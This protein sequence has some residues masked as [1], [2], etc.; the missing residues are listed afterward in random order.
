MDHVF[1]FP[2]SINENVIDKHVGGQK[3]HFSEGWA[4]RKPTMAEMAEAINNGHAFGP[5]FQNGVRLGVNFIRAGFVVIDADGTMSLQDALADPFIQTYGAIIYTTPSHR[6][7]AE[8]HFR[9]VFV[10][11]T[12][13]ESGH[14]YK[15]AL[16][17]L[18]EKFNTDKV[19]D[20]ARVLFGSK[21]S[22]PTILGNILPDRELKA[23]IKLGRK[24]DR[25]RR[26][27]RPAS[28]NTPEDEAMPGGS[29]RA[30]YHV[31][32]DQLLRTAAGGTGLIIDMPWKTPIY[33]PFHA[34]ANPSAFILRSKQGDPG[35]HC[36]SCKKTWWVEG[37]KTPAYDFYAFDRVV[38]EMAVSLPI[39]NAARKAAGKP[40][41][42]KGA[43]VI[44]QKY[45]PE[46]EL[47][48]GFTLVKSPK[49]SG[50]TTALKKLIQQAKRQ[51]KSVLLIGHR[52]VLL[53]ELAAKLG[54]ECYLDD[55]VLGDPAFPRPDYYAIS[56]DSLPRRLQ[57]PRT[58][59]IVIVDE[60]EQVFSHVTAKTIK[61][62]HAVMT[63]LQTYIGDAE[64][65]YLLDADLNQ[66]TLNFVGTARRKDPLQ[67]ARLILNTY[68]AE[69]RVC[70]LF[71]KPTALIADMAEAA[72][73]GKRIFVA[74]NS[75]RRAK[76]LAKMLQKDLGPAARVLLITADEKADQEVQDFLADIPNKILQ[77]NAVVASPAI[78]TGI[79]ITF[80][81]GAQEIDV[82]YGLFNS[83]INSHYDIDQQLGRVRN[84][85]EVKVWVCGR[86]SSFEIDLDAVKRDLVQTGDTHPAVHDFAHGLPVVNM[87]HPLLTLQAT[88]YSAQRASQNRMKEY[89]IR[90]KELNGWKI[91]RIPDTDD[92]NSEKIRAKLGRLQ[93]EIEQEYIGGV[94]NARMI[95]QADWKIYFDRRAAG[96]SIG[97]DAINEMIKCEIRH[98]YNTQVTP[99]L[100]ELDDHAK[101]REC[102][103]RYETL[104]I[105]NPD[106]MRLLKRDWAVYL[107]KAKNLVETLGARPLRSV[108]GVLLS[109]GLIDDQG[110]DGGKIL[111][112]A[113]LADFL[114]FCDDRLVTIERD[115]DINLRKDRH[116]DP[117]R[118][119][120]DCL[121]L[122]GQGMECL[123]KTRKKQVAVYRY[124]LDAGCLQEMRQI[125]ARRK[126]GEYRCTLPEVLEPPRPRRRPP[127]ANANRPTILY[128]DPSEAWG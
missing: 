94:M 7:D 26:V 40:E 115:L 102:V 8:D 44:N 91:V 21:G 86:R 30:D 105:H 23:L 2:L 15:L 126:N 34:D 78:G 89:F 38:K 13:I 28:E 88:A 90:H 116:R 103:A 45:L 42:N 106:Y 67:P 60:S 48:A 123:G 110:L 4:S 56:V 57:R 33:C 6:T 68:I 107:S 37:S 82:V 127:A 19:G 39:T 46:L 50:K 55:I 14:K 119:L 101:F 16:L 120:N 51:G 76:L 32:R 53:R 52:Q 81:E 75:K 10:T 100:I 111:T 118:A 49:G 112:K 66:V 17:G 61:N 108:E 25:A 93:D 70:E 122:I 58:Y 1:R 22:N 72:R 3:R 73:I 63:R 79:D 96:E 59:D 97:T 62:A 36:S 5:Q 117:V 83:G 121:S 84:P 31:P 24:A 87:D 54:L 104:H 128:K 43:F 125:V 77:Y 109:C 74:C 9:V 41:M 20:A 65:L 27:A 85:K 92:E 18:A 124:Q 114:A 99:E 47:R 35:I 29:A 12:P 98:F 113:D 95:D 80:P 11:E 71:P 69:N 64:S